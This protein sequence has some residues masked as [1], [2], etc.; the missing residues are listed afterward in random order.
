MLARVDVRAAAHRLHRHASGVEGLEVDQL[1]WRDLEVGAP[2]AL[3]RDGA[4]HGPGVGLLGDADP[5]R[6]PRAGTD[7]GNIWSTR[8][9]VISAPFGHGKSLS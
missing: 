8:K 3:H 1:A 9:C 4:Q 6:V 7:L 2:V 5:R